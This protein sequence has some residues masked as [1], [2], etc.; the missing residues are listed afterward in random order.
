MLPDGDALKATRAGVPAILP[1][2]ANANFA[3]FSRTRGRY[4][5]LDLAKLNYTQ[6][7]TRAFREM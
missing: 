1:E 3:V 7:H 6:T 2:V 4:F 5:P